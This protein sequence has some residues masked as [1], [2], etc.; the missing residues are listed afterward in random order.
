MDFAV[1]E[2]ELCGAVEKG[3]AISSSILIADVIKNIGDIRTKCFEFQNSD[4]AVVKGGGRQD[5]SAWRRGSENSRS[6]HS[7][8]TNGPDRPRP[9]NGSDHSRSNN[10]S[11]HSRFK[12]ESFSRGNNSKQSVIIPINTNTG[13]NT[14]V[15]NTHGS[16]TAAAKKNNIPNSSESSIVSSRSTKEK[17]V[18]LEREIVSETATAPATAQPTNTYKTP[19]QMKAAGF[20]KSREEVESKIL[21]NLVLS[22]LNKFTKDNYEDIREFLE[23]IL[24]NDETEFLKDFMILVFKKATKEPVFCP[25]YVKLITEL[26]SKYPVIKQELMC[27]YD[28]YLKEFEKVEEE[29][30]K[31]EDYDG[32]CE[33]QTEKIYR[34]G[35]GQFLGEL[36]KKGILDADALLRLYKTIL[37]LINTY[38]APGMNHRNQVEQMAA[39]LSRITSVF[40]KEKNPALISICQ[41]LNK[42]CKS[43]LQD[44]VSRAKKGDLPG[45]SPKGRFALMDCQD[46]FVE[47]C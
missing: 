26:C 23:Q 5:L 2:R 11:D 25:L 13:H 6:D 19:S 22:K 3:V 45:L 44:V 29:N 10:G 1:V 40:K 32:F 35:Y 8:S 9:N 28:T 17:E 30:I 43:M 16:W 47:T 39:C 36:T 15:S 38:S 27:L 18:G 4:T 7:R 34:L 31:D 20:N 41:T 37:E 24:S 42:S 21:N 46:I 12:N 33:L 14:P